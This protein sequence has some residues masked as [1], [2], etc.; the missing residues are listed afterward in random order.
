M[1]HFVK[2]FNN[3]NVVMSIYTNSLL[4]QTGMDNFCGIKAQNVSLALPPCDHVLCL[5]VCPPLFLLYDK[6]LS[7]FLM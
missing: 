7:V 4:S 3:A 6:L 2:C 5:T 1:S